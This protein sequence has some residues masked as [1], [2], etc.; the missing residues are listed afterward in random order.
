MAQSQQPL[1]NDSEI[2]PMIAAKAKNDQ[3]FRPQRTV[4]DDSEV[5][6]MIAAKALNDT[7]FK[8]QL[9]NY[10][11]DHSVRTVLQVIPMFRK[12]IAD[13]A[14]LQAPPLAN[15]RSPDLTSFLRKN[16]NSRLLGKVV[17]REVYGGPVVSM[18]EGS[19]WGWVVSYLKCLE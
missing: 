3:V 1:L 19:E 9:L 4:L 18:K 5:S 11:E 7:F 2:S 17:S 16:T 12:Q 6:R 8:R 15:G 13:Q 10:G 14:K